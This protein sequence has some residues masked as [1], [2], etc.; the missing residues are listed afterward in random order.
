[1]I[2]GG[3][4]PWVAVAGP[5]GK[6]PANCEVTYWTKDGRTLVFVV[7]NVPVGGSSF[8]GGGA[9][10][11]AAGEIPIDVQFAQPVRDAVDERTGKRL[12]D[13]RK[14]RFQFNRA[15]AVFMSFQGGPR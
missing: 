12:G 2:D 3:A 6:R 14:F 8:G 5:D 7:Q 9:E 10:G 4:K 15:E 13:G 11:L 1:M